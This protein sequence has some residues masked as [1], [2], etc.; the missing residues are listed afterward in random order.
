MAPVFIFALVALF[1]LSSCQTPRDE[2]NPSQYRHHKTYTWGKYTIDVASWGQNGS[3]SLEYCQVKVTG[4]KNDSFILRMDMEIAEGSWVTDMDR[5]GNFEV[6][7]L[8]RSAGSG[9]FGEIRVFEWDGK[10]LVARPLPELTAKQ[11]TG[12]YGHDAFKVGTNQIVHEFPVYKPGD[13]NASPTGG[14]RRL[15][16]TFADKKWNASEE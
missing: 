14:L 13:P 6:L 10:A 8:G 11:A 4:E 7:I 12:Y 2:I 1:G 16:Y 5:D 3:A 9:S 15:V